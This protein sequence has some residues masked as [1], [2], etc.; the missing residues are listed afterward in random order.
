M[1]FLLSPHP[2]KAKRKNITNQP[3]SSSS[4]KIV[5]LPLRQSMETTTA[6]A[7]QEHSKD[8]FKQELFVWEIVMSVVVFAAIYFA[9]NAFKKHEEKAKAHNK[10]YNTGE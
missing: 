6:Q 8:K 5:S 9:L 7:V 10:K 1:H 2:Y 3:A 4:L